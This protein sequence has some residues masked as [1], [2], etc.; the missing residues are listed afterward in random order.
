[1]SAALTLAVRIISFNNFIRFA[2][3]TTRFLAPAFAIAVYFFTRSCYESSRCPHRGLTGIKFYGGSGGNMPFLKHKNNDPHSRMY[4][5][6]GDALT[7]R[8][9]ICI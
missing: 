7:M 5:F 8:R 2:L 9:L 3:A 4:I 6:M 1:M